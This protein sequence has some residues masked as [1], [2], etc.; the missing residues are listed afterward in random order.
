MNVEM[1]SP[2]TGGRHRRTDTYGG[3]MTNAEKE[4]YYSLSPRDALAYDLKNLKQIYM[5][6]GLYSEIRPQL[7]KY[8]KEYIKYKPEIFKK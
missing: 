2:G 3:N 5:D 1:P 8:I 6:D 7:R 4:Y